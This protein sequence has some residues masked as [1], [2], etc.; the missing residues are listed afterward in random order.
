LT[1]DRNKKGERMHRRARLATLLGV[2]T[3][4]LA[5]S[6]VV[7][8]N[9][10]E[11]FDA[12]NDGEVLLYYFGN[13]R[14]TDGNPVDKFMV[15][16]EAKNAD[17]TM[18]FRNDTPGHFRSP[19]VGKAIKGMGKPVDPRFIEVRIEKDGYQVVKAPVVPDKQGAVELEGF[20]LA[21]A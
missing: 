21:P 18:P 4:A 6:G 19:D 14:D 16:V 2:V 9:G 5:T 7:R 1:N 11:F 8:A 13:V 17:L 15:Y 3:L 12:Q 10:T 20:V